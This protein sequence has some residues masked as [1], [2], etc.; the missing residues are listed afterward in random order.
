MEI[1]V[2]LCKYTVALKDNHKTKNGVA[3]LSNKIYCNFHLIDFIELFWFMKNLYFAQNNLKWWH[4]LPLGPLQT[5]WINWILK[6][7]FKLLALFLVLLV[8]GEEFIRERRFPY[9]LPSGIK[10]YHFFARPRQGK[11]FQINLC[12]RIF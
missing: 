11:H 2:T 7:M 10:M 12:W 3:V 6:V 9:H 5:Y 4:V 1:Y 8:V